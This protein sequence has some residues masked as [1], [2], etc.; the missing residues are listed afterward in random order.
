[1]YIYIYIY[2]YIYKTWKLIYDNGLVSRIYKEFFQLNNKEKNLMG[3]NIWTDTSQDIQVSNQCRK[4]L[5][6]ISVKVMQIK[7]TMKDYR[8]P[9][10]MDNTKKA[11]IPSA[12]KDIEQLR[13]SYNFGR[14]VKQ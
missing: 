2:I 14:N 7:T 6:I 8:Q 12:C 9:I 10:K 13:C 11:I 1:M 3:K 5:N 4:M